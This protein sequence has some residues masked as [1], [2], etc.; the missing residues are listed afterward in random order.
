M[1]IN[2]FNLHL[3]A[4]T[5]SFCSNYAKKI[6]EILG[7][8]KVFKDI[9]AYKRL[10]SMRWFFDH[11]IQSEV[12]NCFNSLYLLVSNCVKEAEISFI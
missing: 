3:P 2:L 12:T 11:F 6:V 9:E 8:S 5:L 1:F 4:F 7:F 10:R